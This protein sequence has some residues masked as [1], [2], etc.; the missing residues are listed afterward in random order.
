MSPSK[1]D[2]TPDAETL[3]NEADKYEEM[4]DLKKAFKCLLAAAQ[5]GD[6]WGQVNLGNF[7]ASGTGVRRSLEKAAH[8]YKKAHKNGNST[9]ALNLAIDRRNEGHIKSAVIWFK[10][11]IAMNCGE[12]CVALAKLYNA[13]RGGQKA[14]GALLRRA[15]RLSRDDISDAARAEAES[16]LREMAKTRKR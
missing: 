9:A 15:L 16:F 4:G 13:R 14:A 10:K 2:K 11:A 12:A 7:Y 1:R 5:L 3:L 6:P 8:W